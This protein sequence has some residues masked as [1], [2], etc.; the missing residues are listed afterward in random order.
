MGTNSCKEV[1]IIKEK[2]NWHVDQNVLTMGEKIKSVL[3]V[4]L[5]T[6]GLDQT[7]LIISAS[8]HSVKSSTPPS[9]FCLDEFG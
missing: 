6:E 3:F 2:E 5:C 9:W 4:L 7:T 8:C 1:I